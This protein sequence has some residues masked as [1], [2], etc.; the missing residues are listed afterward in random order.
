MRRL[1][2]AISLFCALFVSTEASAYRYGVA[3][4]PGNATLNIGQGDL[5]PANMVNVLN[6]AFYS[7]GSNSDASK[8]DADGIPTSA[9]TSS[10]SLAF[11]TNVQFTNTQYKFVWGAGRQMAIAF[12]GTESACTAVNATVTGCSSGN[13][14]IQTNGSAGSVAFTTTD[15]TFSISFPSTGTYSGSG[16]IALYRTSD[17][18]R[19]QAGKYWTQ[20]YINLIKALK[21]YALRMMGLTDGGQ[22][23]F[24]G[25]TNWAYRIPATA[26]SWRMN[27]VIPAQYVSSGCSGTNT[28]SVAAASGSPANW[29]DGEVIQCL[30]GAS[31][32]NTST[33]ATLAITGHT[34]TKTIFD[35]YAVDL[36]VGDIG[37]GTVATFVYDA[38]LDKVLSIGTAGNA[39][40]GLP[41]SVPIEAQ[42][43]LCNEVRSNCWIT[44]PQWAS[45][46]YVT[47]QATYV[48]NNLASDL[49]FIP[50]YSNEIWNT[51]FPQTYWASVRGQALGFT[52]SSNEHLHG[53]YGLRVRQIMGNLIPAV[54]SGRMSRLRRSLAYQAA[55]DQ[56][57]YV[58]RM[59]GHDLAP[60]GVGTGQGN[61]TYCTWTGGTFSGTCTGGANYTTSPNRPIDVVDA[62]NY[63]PYAGGTNLM[64]GPDIAGVDSGGDT[65]TTINAPFYQSLINAIEAGNTATANSLIDNDVRGGVTST[66]TV[67]ASG[68]TFTT[69]ANHNFAPATTGLTNVV[70]TVTGGTMYSGLTAG[71]VYRVSTTPTSNTFT[72]QAYQNSSNSS[73]GSLINAGTAGS[74]TVSVS[75]MGGS[76]YPGLGACST[77]TFNHSITTVQQLN[78]QY[79]LFAEWLAAQFDADR[80]SRGAAL[81]RTDQY[82]GAL[83]LQGP[84]NA[85][86]SAISV[87]GASTC[88]ADPATCVTNAI[89]T[90]KNSALAS[91]TI[92]DYYKQSKG[93]V[94]G[95]P[96]F[97]VQTHAG[98]PAQLVFAATAC[99][100]IQSLSCT[101]LP[102]FTPYQLYYGFQA[103]SAN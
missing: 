27:Y 57:T 42:V 20:E 68:T 90:W 24:N 95:Y 18:A 1:L 75:W 96:T 48:Y 39:T 65:P 85:Q 40:N 92:Q 11:Y 74:G 64:F 84:T 78:S 8:L 103:F 66:Q 19:Y 53:W 25:E 15:T 38:L 43:Q 6:S 36:K 56:T 62:I 58:Y 89:E 100:N 99:G 33:T 61:S 54:W 52:S 73:G 46:N 14:T 81:L 51:G 17:E 5:I 21:P 87:T 97:G 71:Q 16:H 35:H 2:A 10:I 45:D 7:L 26:V 59:Q 49:Y 22:A 80:N 41:A 70:F 63:A 101:P 76:C 28:Y 94:A 44:I 31:S 23:N 37:S 4:A 34:G 67:S 82:E 69:P 29:T 47:Q 30:I 88:A 9:L 13:M 3:G 77:T 98:A 86:L 93:L 55:G 102:N 12:S 79:Y 60:S 83:E 72:I 91:L 50:E 32:G